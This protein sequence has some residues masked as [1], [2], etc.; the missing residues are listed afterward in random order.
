MALLFCLYHTDLDST[1]PSFEEALRVQYDIVVTLDRPVVETEITDEEGNITIVR[2]PVPMSEAV[3]VES[4]VYHGD[5]VAIGGVPGVANWKAVIAQSSEARLRQINT[6]TKQLEL[7]R[8]KD[9]FMPLAL[10][11]KDADS[12]YYWVEVL[13]ASDRAKITTFVLNRFGLVV[14]PTWTD[15]QLVRAIFQKIQSGFDINHFGIADEDTD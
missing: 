4:P 12:A 9:L 6:Q 8:G 5:V 7:T 2:V 1:D 3:E 10:R 15:E 14:D 13:S 11:K